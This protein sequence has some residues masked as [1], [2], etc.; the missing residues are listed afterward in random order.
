MAIEFVLR[1]TLWDLHVRQSAAAIKCG[2]PKNTMCRWC[3]GDMQSVNLTQLDKI[4]TGLNIT[5]DQVLKHVP[6]T[7]EPVSDQ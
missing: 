2:I 4:L 3:K 6:D 7:A 5:I 1:D